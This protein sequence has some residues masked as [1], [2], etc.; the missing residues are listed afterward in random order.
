MTLEVLRTLGYEA[1]GLGA[2][3]LVLPAENLLAA[4]NGLLD[5]AG[6]SRVVSA[7]VALFGMTSGEVTA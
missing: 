5:D 2:A 7:N 6:Q 4:T 3:D 1:V